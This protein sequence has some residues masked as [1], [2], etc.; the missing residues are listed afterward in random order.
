MANKSRTAVQTAINTNLADNSTGNISAADTRGTQTDLNDS[1]FNIISDDADVIVDGDAKVLMIPAE[2]TK[3]S[4]IDVSLPVNLDTQQALVASAEQTANKGAANGYASLGSD[5][6]IPSAQIP[7]IAISEYLGTA[8]DQTAMLLLSG[9][10]GDWCVRTDTGTNFIITGNDPSVIGGWTE[11]SYPTAPVTSVNG[12][13][14]VV[15][16]D[17][18]DIAE[19]GSR[20]WLVSGSQTIGGP[21]TFSG[22]VTTEN[23]LTL[24]DDLLGD[25]SARVY[26]PVGTAISA[27]ANLEAL[28]PNTFYDV[29]ATGG[30]VVITV[31]DTANLLFA[32]GTEFEFSPID[33]TN[34]VS[35]I[36]IG[37]QTIDSKDG[38]LKL[39]GVFSGSVLK[40]TAANTWRLIGTLKA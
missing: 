16:L 18:Q 1:S 25:Q 40:K 10:K 9:E 22:A 21:K 32:V 31:T 19:A 2:R 5:S 34:D 29:D 4:F 7:D 12:D 37:S 13:T 30:A 39:D 28:D 8:A 6:K 11:L 15:V 27:S 24:E 38:N 33:L 3:L 17:A 26:R 35:F 36:G 23:T 20:V 14:G